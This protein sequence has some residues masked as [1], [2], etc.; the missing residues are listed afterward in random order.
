MPVDNTATMARNDHPAFEIAEGEMNIQNSRIL[1]FVDE[2]ESDSFASQVNLLDGDF[3]SP[4]FNFLEADK[5][6]IEDESTFDKLATR[7]ALDE[8]SELEKSELRHLQKRRHELY[9]VRSID[10]ILSD[11]RKEKALNDILKSL[12]NYARIFAIKG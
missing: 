9:A 2:G 3:S 11:F 4:T 12:N 6:S 1:E 8:A 10:D 5:W 7:F